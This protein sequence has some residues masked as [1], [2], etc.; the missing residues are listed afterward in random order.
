LTQI[1]RTPIDFVSVKADVYEP[2]AVPSRQAHNEL[3]EFL[4]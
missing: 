4:L 2:A 3:D 1:A